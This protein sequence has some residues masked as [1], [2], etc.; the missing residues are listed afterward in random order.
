MRDKN[1]SLSMSRPETAIPSRPTSPYPISVHS[2]VVCGFGRGSSELGIPTANIPINDVLNSL[3]TGIYYGWCQVIPTV[4]KQTTTKRNDGQ[5]VSINHGKTLNGVELE[6]LPMVMS[7]GW[8]PFYN[9]KE[10]AAEVHIVHKFKDNFYG[11]DIRFNVLGYIRPELNYT[12]KEALIDDI[13]LDIKIGVEILEREGY[14]AYK[15]KFE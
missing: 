6:S 11:A 4:D 1:L 15:G 9:N 8:N 3:E 14:K 10:K 13:N 5:E 12:T 7:I 2:K